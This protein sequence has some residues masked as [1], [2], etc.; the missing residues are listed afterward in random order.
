MYDKKK[1]DIMETRT[2]TDPFHARYPGGTI[3]IKEGTHL[4]VHESELIH[5][6]VQIETNDKKFIVSANLMYMNTTPQPI[7]AG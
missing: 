2:V 1:T 7:A 3:L 5:T 4:T 6:L